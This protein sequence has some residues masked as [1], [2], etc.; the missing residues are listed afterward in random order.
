MKHL[1]QFLIRLQ[2][3]HLHIQQRKVRQGSP[4]EINEVQA[5]DIRHET[6][7]EEASA[8][9]SELRLLSELAVLDLITLEVVQLQTVDRLLSLMER[10]FKTFWLNFHGQ[11]AEFRWQHYPSGYI[12]LVGLDKLFVVQNLRAAH[13]HVLIEETFVDD[14]SE[15]VKLREF[16]LA[17]LRQHVNSLVPVEQVHATSTIPP[18]AG[19]PVRRFPRFVEGVAVAFYDILKGYFAQHEQ[20]L[21]LPLLQE[22]LPP[23][24]PLVFHGNGNQLADAFKQLY[25]ANLIVG[26]LKGDLEEWISRHFAYVFRKQQ[27]TLPPNYLAAIISSNVKPCQSPILDVKKQPDGTYAVF[28]VL[29]TQ[30]N[31]NSR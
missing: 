24:S 20:Q 17:S 5:Y 29:R 3:F 4:A 13:A 11:A 27:R 15:S 10:R 1:K 19:E 14:L 6:P 22:N 18:L 16:L 28:P 30:K 21:L 31:Y 8:F 23:A 7:Y 12:S 9:E 25:E 2:T 26:C